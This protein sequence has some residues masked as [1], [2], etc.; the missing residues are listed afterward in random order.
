MTNPSDRTTKVL[1]ALL[2][3]GVWALLLRPLFVASPAQAQQSQ[4][5]LSQAGQV[6][7]VVNRTEAVGETLYVFYASGG[8]Y[9]MKAFRAI[10]Q[11]GQ[12]GRLVIQESEAKELT[13]N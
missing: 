6:P 1:L 8:T 7:T 5:V 4:L 10:P 11:G 9:K 3:A 2:V 13:K 12:A